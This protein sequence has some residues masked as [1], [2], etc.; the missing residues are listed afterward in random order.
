MTAVWH[1]DTTTLTVGVEIGADVRGRDIDFEVH[2]SRMRLST[3]GE[4]ALE[5]DFPEKVDPV[6]S[7]FN[8]EERDDKRMCVITLEKK[9]MGHE[10]WKEFFAEDAVDTTITTKVRGDLCAVAAAQRCFFML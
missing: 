10:S 8:I 6:G 1:Q 3:S 2:P 9:T 4:I 5:G 7:F